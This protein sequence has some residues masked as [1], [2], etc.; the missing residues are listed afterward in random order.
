MAGQSLGRLGQTRESCDDKK[1]TDAVKNCINRS[2]PFGDNDWVKKTDKK[3]GLKL[4]LRPRG[5]LKKVR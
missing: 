5:R 2:S 1:E 3:Q 4:T